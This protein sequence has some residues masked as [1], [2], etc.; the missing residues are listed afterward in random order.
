MQ[1]T[2]AYRDRSNTMINRPLPAARK[3]MHPVA[4]RTIESGTVVIH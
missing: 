1:V 2:K 4:E 3:A